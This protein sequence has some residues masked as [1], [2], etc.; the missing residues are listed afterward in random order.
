MDS[1]GNSVDF[2]LTTD[3]K[4]KSISSTKESD[5]NRIEMS[6][7]DSKSRG[8]HN[9]VSIAEI[10]KRNGTMFSSQDSDEKLLSPTGSVPEFLVSDDDEP[11]NSKEDFDQDEIKNMELFDPSMVFISIHRCQYWDD[12]DIV[13][14]GKMFMTSTELLF[15]CS[16]MPFVKLRLPLRE[17]TEVK[18]T[19]NYRSCK[20]KIE[21][22]IVIET[23]SGKSHAFF[24]FKIPK[25]IIKNLIM[26]LVEKSKSLESQSSTKSTVFQALENGNSETATSPTEST[27]NVRFRKMNPVKEKIN[28][29]IGQRVSGERRDSHESGADTEKRGSQYDAKNGRPVSLNLDPNDS[30]GFS[31]SPKF[32][33]KIL[34]LLTPDG[35]KPKSVDVFW[36]TSQPTS[37]S[38]TASTPSTPPKSTSTTPRKL[39]DMSVN[40]TDVEVVKLVEPLNHDQQH[41]LKQKLAQTGIVDIETETFY[42]EKNNQKI[43][44]ESMTSITTFRMTRKQKEDT[45]VLLLML[46]SF[47][48]FTIITIN[49]LIKI[50]QVEYAFKSLM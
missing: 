9:S 20:N 17:I 34:K 32:K 13:R 18:R 40:K 2:Y 46:F 3:D 22:F 1:I 44:V 23:K 19:R 45:C 48:V 35:R 41:K 42:E 10:Q 29:L 8:R 30:T 31:T 50:N 24:K 37:Q 33:P 36:P 38:A 15:K 26:E 28:V 39:S 5:N 7:A 11:D 16:R 6:P 27:K 25:N 14:K 47:I 4:K 43:L 12:K 49:N 21:S